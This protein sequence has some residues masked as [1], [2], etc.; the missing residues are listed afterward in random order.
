MEGETAASSELGPL[1]I[2]GGTSIGA[3]N[4]S[5]STC[6]PTRVSTIS[7]TS[8][9]SPSHTR[10]SDSSLSSLPRMSN[11]RMSSMELPSTRD[12]IK[13]AQEQS[14]SSERLRFNHLGVQG[15][16]KEK[17]VLLQSVDNCIAGGREIV[18]IS[19]KSGTGKTSLAQTIS[20]RVEKAEGLIIRGKCDTYLRQ[21]PFAG[22]AGACR[23]VCGAILQ[24]K[25][26]D[27]SKE[28]HSIFQEIRDELVDKIE[29]E[30]ILILTEIL[31][32]EI[33]E[34]VDL[35]IASIHRSTDRDSA[36]AKQRLQHS[37]LQFFRVVTK[38]IGPLVVILD[39][40]Q[41]TDSA[42]TELIRAWITDQESS[43][44]LV[45]CIYRSDEVD[46]NHIVT[47]MTRELN[48]KSE[49]F[50]FDLTELVISEFTVPEVNEIL[51]ELMSI[52]DD[53][54]TLNLAVICHKR[55]AGNAF[56]LLQFIKQLWAMKLLSFSY[57]KFEFLWD[58]HDIVTQ[59]SATTN[60]VDMMTVL[61]TSLPEEDQKRLSIAAFLGAS[62]NPSVLDIVWEGMFVDSTSA[63]LVTATSVNNDDN[64]GCLAAAELVGIIERQETPS[65]R[66]SYRWAHDSIQ[67]A[68]MALVPVADLTRMKNQIGEILLKRLNDAEKESLIFVIAN[69]LNDATEGD[70][71]E[72]KLM[73]AKV[74]LQAAKRA[75]LFS[76][77]DT[78]AKYANHGIDHLPSNSW[79]QHFSLT[80]DLYCT[81]LE[82]EYSCGMPEQMLAHYDIVVAN[83]K[84]SRMDK[85]RAHLP[86]VRHFNGSLQHQKASDLLV[87]LLDQMGHRLPKSKLSQVIS[88]VGGMMSLK[89]QIQKIG[90]DDIASLPKMQSAHDLA[91]MGLLERLSQNAYRSNSK[92]YLPLSVLSMVRLTLSK[93]VSEHSPVAIVTF[94]VILT[95]IWKDYKLAYKCGQLAEQLSD[96]FRLRETEGRTMMYINSFTKAWVEPLFYLEASLTQAYKLSLAV[97]DTAMAMLVSSNAA[98]IF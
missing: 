15:R 46:E 49:H 16:T 76:S 69:L 3:D 61:L 66:N 11:K 88:T 31:S 95:A 35:D 39:D 42:S 90:I 78:C 18:F 24:L 21:E 85:M 74:N 25:L 23:E 48:T 6:Q 2:D 81:A 68:A 51:M 20:R 92:M 17:E 27:M 40:I 72:D 89:K 8:H 29:A 9:E 1:T 43:R 98:S 70:H 57:G 38:Y 87:Q 64:I 33:S 75:T 60:V 50:G 67:E 34:I 19:G 71:F 96:R 91:I 45:L 73:I 26:G 55:T 37:F 7:S 65:N 10:L 14:I 59:T 79:E 28:K 62:L 83:E 22:I 53:D 32:P 82:A 84:G 58:E 86:M 80:L 30:D 4:A 52:D 54:R 93:G 41:W 77:F 12:M 13:S 63:G 44:L 47:S 36:K 94:G 56:F 97:G 5:L